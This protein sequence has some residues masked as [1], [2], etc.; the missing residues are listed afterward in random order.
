MSIVQ[1]P[2]KE[3]KRLNDNL[4]PEI[5][6]YL[7]WLSEN[8]EQ[9]FLKECELP[10]HHPLLSGLLHPG[11]AYTSGLRFGKDGNNTAGRMI[12]GQPR[13]HR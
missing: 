3:R 6:E 12:S 8:L 13:G 10:P 2:T 4:D 9:Y 7:E 5:R 1:I 11:G